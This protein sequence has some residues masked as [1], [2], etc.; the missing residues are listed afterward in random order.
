MRIGFSGTRRGMT[1]VQMHVVEAALLDKGLGEITAV[2]HGDCIGAD[3]EFHAIAIRLGLRTVIHPP[4][5]EVLRAWCGGH[6]IYACKPYLARN[7]D[8]LA[9][10]DYLIAVPYEYKE[11]LRGSGVW[12]MIR[13]AR[14]SHLPHGI[15]YPGK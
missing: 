5:D 14:K 6:E 15:V 1:S 13:A 4:E 7:R 8:I 3:A 9:A 12:A 10:C 2:H 11:R